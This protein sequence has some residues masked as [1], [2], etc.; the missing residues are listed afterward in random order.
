LNPVFTFAVGAKDLEISIIC[1]HAF[2]G[3]ERYF[4][5]ELLES[6]EIMNSTLCYP[7]K[8]E[9]SRIDITREQLQPL[10]DKMVDS[11]PTCEFTEWG[12]DGVSYS[13][14]INRDGGV[15]TFQWWNT[16][17]KGYRGFM[18][19][20]NSIRILMKN[21]K[22]KSAKGTWLNEDTL[23][24]LAWGKSYERGV[25]YFQAGA[26]D[27]L[28]YSQGWAIAQ[29]IGSDT[30]QVRL[31]VD[32]MTPEWQCDCPVGEDGLFCK[33]CV[34]V[35]L[36]WL[37]RIEKGE[38]ETDSAETLRSYLEQ[39][40][41][42]AL[43][44]WL[45]DAAENHPEL[46]QRLMAENTT[47]APQL[48]IKQ[49]KQQ[50][51]QALSVR[52]FV[53]YR[54]MRRFVTRV[55]PVVSMLE[56]MVEQGRSTEALQLLQYALEVGLKNLEK[57][58]DSDG[59]FSD[60]L[61]GL[62]E[63]HHAAAMQAR[64]D[65]KKFAKDF[66]KLRMLDGWSFFSLAAYEPVLGDDGLAVYRKLV[67][68]EWD[69]VPPKKAG[70]DEG[71]YFGEHFTIRTRMEELAERDQD[72][73]AL[74]AI[75]ARD[76][77]QVYAYS[78]IAEILFNANRKDEAIGWAERGYKAFPNEHKHSLVDFLIKA[79]HEVKR[80][81]DAEQLAWKEFSAT[82]SLNSYQ[83]LKQSASKNKNWPA[84][85]KKA[86]TLL[87]KLVQQESSNKAKP[88]RY[89]FTPR[90]TRGVLQEIL[91]WEKQIDEAVTQ[92]KT[93]GCP[94]YLIMK[95]A[96][97]CE[98]SHKTEAINLYKNEIQRLVDRRNNDSYAEAAKLVAKVGKLYKQLKQKAEF[99]GYV[100]DLR[101]EHKA[102]RNFMKCLDGV[103]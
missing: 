18:E 77:S 97:A 14:S 55:R 57:T 68:Q 73:D 49:V 64:P 5:R 37:D 58:D 47:A 34:A 26:V 99:E 102:K 38:V 92:M 80:H 101:K 62:A 35:G 52:G 8:R 56:G 23:M 21:K 4:I 29:V 87:D 51:R 88:S 12:L 1:D 75:K 48:D 19:F 72:I 95:M 50:I 63:S 31:R 39:Q 103:L 76:L 70:K 94:M 3:V 89:A 98:K 24:D 85:R 83:T 78:D 79:Y 27:D 33:H 2:E 22:V 15:Q 42:N 54:G 65:A 82:P 25:D 32:G 41:K 67:Q 61:G 60:L 11:L 69:K 93:H 91:L 84:C 81:K 66:F 74:V 16:G 53:D 96:Q 28:I 43:I 44:A 86:R 45:I 30:Y 71:S 100:S 9:S 46:R 90:S 7:A 10:I 17:G 40:D 13:V 20:V 59:G 36:V 6:F